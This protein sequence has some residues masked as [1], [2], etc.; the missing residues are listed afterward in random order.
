MDVTIKATPVFEMNYYSNKRYVV[1][2]GG[3]RSSKTYSILQVLI[4]KALE[5]DKPLTLSIVRKT[6]PAL[7]KSVLKDFIAILESM[8]L[9]NANNYNKTEGTYELNSSL[10]EF[11]SVDDEMKIRG[12]KRDYLFINE[13]N[14]L[15]YPDFFQ[16]QIRTTEQVFMDYNPSENVSWVY[17]LADTRTDEV[18]FFKTTYKD[19]PY[20]E[21]SIV[22]EIERLKDTDDDYYRIYGLG[23]KGGSRELVYQYTLIDNIPVE[24]AKLVG[25][26][27]DFGYVNDE[28]AVVEVWQQNDALYLNE[29]VYQRGLT[30]ADIANVLKSYGIDRTSEIIADSAEPKSIEELRRYGFNTHAAQK[31]PDSILNGIDI[32]KRNRLHITKA[33]T[34]LIKELNAYKWMKDSAGNLINKPL[35][36]MNHLLD[37]AR[38]VCLNK[39]KQHNAGR[40]NISIIGTGGDNTRLNTGIKS[41]IR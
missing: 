22:A 21:A 29:L 13:C 18:D 11:F 33:S 6:L 17:D 30:N 28:T 20:L 27:L 34:N 36:Y 41:F 16:L 37:A 38:Y 7:K 14:E 4:L 24:L 15:T 39:L 40:Y 8:G 19:N 3:T 31:G 9:Y 10:F 23:E 32:M 25:I 12:S 1:N 5:S 35:D 26:G 2:Q